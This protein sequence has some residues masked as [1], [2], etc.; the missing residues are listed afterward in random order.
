[1]YPL[2]ENSLF[3]G[4][5]VRKW[6]RIRLS[7]TIYGATQPDFVVS[8]AFRETVRSKSA[9]ERPPVYSHLLSNSSIGRGHPYHPPW[10]IRHRLLIPKNQPQ[11]GMGRLVRLV[12]NLWSFQR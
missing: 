8:R 2:L 4:R 12:V 5:V 10:E 7:Q 9:R 6:D 3:R 11:A 1:M